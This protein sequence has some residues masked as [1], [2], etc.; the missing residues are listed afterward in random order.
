MY[1]GLKDLFVKYA[2]KWLGWLENN[3]FFLLIFVL[4]IKG[5]KFN[6]FIIVLDKM[7]NP[8]PTY[9]LLRWEIQSYVVLD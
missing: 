4:F 1:F 9:S 8:A 6:F 2:Y 7:L 5:G 3:I